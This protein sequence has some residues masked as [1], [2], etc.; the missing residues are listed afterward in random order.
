MGILGSFP[1][2]LEE[3]TFAEVRINDGLRGNA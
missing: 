3:S 1:K 2:K